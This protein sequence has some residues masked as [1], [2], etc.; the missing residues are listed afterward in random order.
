MSL[1]SEGELVCISSKTGI[2]LSRRFIVVLI[3]VEQYFVCW[4][5]VV[6]CCLAPGQPNTNI[7]KREGNPATVFLYL[8][9]YIEDYL[10]IHLVNI[11]YPTGP[12]LS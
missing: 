8:W 12:F 11:R 1:W 7:I 3:T 5:V 9:G 6:G 10:S 4:V 2:P